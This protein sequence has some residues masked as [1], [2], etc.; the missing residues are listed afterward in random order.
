MNDEKIYDVLMEIKSDVAT[1]KAQV[2]NVISQ[3]TNHER[4]LV[5]LETVKQPEKDDFKTEMLKLLGKGIVIGLI[6]I[7]SLTG[8]GSILSKF[9][10][11]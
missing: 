5:Q 6:I 10:A 1:V 11:M 8:A 2:S 9:I 4:R 3:L 7:G